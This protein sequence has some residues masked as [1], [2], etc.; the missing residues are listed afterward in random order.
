MKMNQ[1]ITI[2]IVFKIFILDRLVITSFFD[3]HF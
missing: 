3:E 2:E 1:F